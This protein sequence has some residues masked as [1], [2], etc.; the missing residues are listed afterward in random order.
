MRFSIKD[1]K[2]DSLLQP[3][4]LERLLAE[5]QVDRAWSHDG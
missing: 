1:E 3:I 4:G 5:F 2:D